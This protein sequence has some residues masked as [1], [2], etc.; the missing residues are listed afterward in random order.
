MNT[1]GAGFSAP[2][3]RRPVS[4]HAA[5]GIWHVTELSKLGMMAAFTNAF[6]DM[7]DLSV[8]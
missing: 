1:I 8:G 2:T 3:A 7:P 4:S 5:E 6:V